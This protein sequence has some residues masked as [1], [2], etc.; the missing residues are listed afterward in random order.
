MFYKLLYF[1][2]IHIVQLRKKF[3]VSKN[4]LQQP[5]FLVH[6]VK[7]FTLIRLQNIL[8]DDKVKYFEVDYF[9]SK[10]FQRFW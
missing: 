4:C 10:L 8:M 2:I 1:L 3:Y 7:I 6:L 9:S 5:V